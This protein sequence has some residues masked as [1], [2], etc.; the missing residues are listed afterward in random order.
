MGRDAPAEILALPLGIGILAG[1]RTVE[2]NLEPSHSASLFA[3]RI[4]GPAGKIVP[5]YVARLMKG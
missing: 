1:A 4:Y 2:L 5:E 3:E